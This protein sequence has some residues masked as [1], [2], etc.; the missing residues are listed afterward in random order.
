MPEITFI[1]TLKDDK[2]LLAVY[3]S[4]HE[5]QLGSISWN[6]KLQAYH[7]Y[8]HCHA[9]YWPEMLDTIS[10]KLRELNSSTVA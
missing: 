7:F 5:D 10:A 3:D 8:P 9:R 2:K 4:C 1:E 6:E